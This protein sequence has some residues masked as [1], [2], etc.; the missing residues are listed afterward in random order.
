[1]ET[2]TV[3]QK[4]E[5]ARQHGER[6]AHEIEPQKLKMMSGNTHIDKKKVGKVKTKLFMFSRRLLDKQS[7]V[8]AIA[9]QLEASGAD[10]SQKEE[11][12]EMITPPERNQLDKVKHMTNK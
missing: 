1:M 4:D 10:P 11:I 3:L 7:R 6:M 5:M 12:E 8:E 2:G 9:A